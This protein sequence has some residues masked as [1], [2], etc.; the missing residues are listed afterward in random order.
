MCEESSRA[1]AGTDSP[2]SVGSSC[3]IRKIVKVRSRRISRR[4]LA[5]CRASQSSLSGAAGGD[6]ARWCARAGAG[7]VRRASGGDRAAVGE[8][9]GSRSSA[10]SAAPPRICQPRCPSQARHGPTAAIT[11]S[12]TFE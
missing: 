10:R 1:S 4:S 12:S 6:D 11:A 3:T 9:S 2:S 8:P 5:S 7:A